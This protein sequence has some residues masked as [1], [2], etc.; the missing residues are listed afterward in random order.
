VQ[1]DVRV[2][3]GAERVDEVTRMLGGEDAPPPARRHAEELL[4]KAKQR[5]G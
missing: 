5:G 2:V 1:A 4:R 3:A